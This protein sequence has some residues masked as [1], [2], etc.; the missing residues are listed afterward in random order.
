MKFKTKSGNP[1]SLRTA[2]MVVG[3]FA[4]DRL[5][6]T[7]KI[8]DKASDGYLAQALG[9]SHMEGDE[10]Q[11]LMLYDVPGCT[12]ERV[13]LVGCGKADE[14]DAARFRKAAATALAELE[15]HRITEATWSDLR[16]LLAGA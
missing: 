13:L 7:A 10:E 4:R 3:V 16:R 8:L 14:F 12:C 5:D 1:A 9:K 11:A 15:R 6:E 2:C